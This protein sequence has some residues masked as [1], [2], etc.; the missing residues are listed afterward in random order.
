MRKEAA[1]GEKLNHIALTA[2][3]FLPFFVRAR[4]HVLQARCVHHLESG[5]T[6]LAATTA[7]MSLPPEEDEMLPSTSGDRQGEG[8]SSGPGPSTSGGEP[9]GAGHG[10]AAG[11]PPDVRAKVARPGAMDRLLLGVFSSLPPG[12]W[13]RDHLSALPP[14][15]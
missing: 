9:E 14:V 12:G 4:R 1:E 13:S 2:R 3:P 8:G 11:A 6:A 7:S 10:A 15:L 5:F